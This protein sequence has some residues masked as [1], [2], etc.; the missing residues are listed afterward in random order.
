LKT[1]RDEAGT[2]GVAGEVEDTGGAGDA[3]DAGPVEDE[4]G[5]SIS[6]NSRK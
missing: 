1:F 3:A 2:A 5:S 6:L 4:A